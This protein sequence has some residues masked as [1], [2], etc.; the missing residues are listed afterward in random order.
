MAADGP[1]ALTSGARRELA[2]LLDRS[3]TPVA[4]GA[5]EALAHEADLT[6]GVW[7]SASGARASTSWAPARTPRSPR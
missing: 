5:Y 1:A 4:L 6:P 7:R 3:G 2:A